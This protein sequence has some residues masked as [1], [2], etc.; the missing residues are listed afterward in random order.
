MRLVFL[1]LGEI[2]HGGIG[3]YGSPCLS[4]VGFG[5]PLQHLWPGFSPDCVLG[6][7]QPIGSCDVDIGGEYD[8]PV[9]I[10]ERVGGASPQPFPQILLYLN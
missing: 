1:I 7:R 2:L 3:D 8:E 5:Q 4:A 9:Y 10:L 6:G